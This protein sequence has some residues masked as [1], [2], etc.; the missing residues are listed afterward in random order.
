MTTAYMLSCLCDYNNPINCYIMTIKALRISNFR[1]FAY[2]EI[3][4]V[5][6]SLNIICGNNGDG[7]TSLLEAIYYLGL[8]RSFR[9]STVSRLLKHGENVF[10]L[11]SQLVT[12]THDL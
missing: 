2:I 4:P 12:S 11:Y 6:S 9:T 5:L 8:G 1:N 10:S 7:K 3:K